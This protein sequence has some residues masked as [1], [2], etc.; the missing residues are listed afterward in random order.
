LSKK[1]LIGNFYVPGWGGPATEGYKMFE[2]MQ[3][4]GL[5]VSY[6]NI[7]SRPILDFFKNKFGSNFG[8]PKGL[9]N[10]YNY[11]VEW[12]ITLDGEHPGLS[13]F[14]NKLSPDITVGKMWRA[15]FLL[16][17]AAPQ[18]PMIFLPSGCDQLKTYI[19]RGEVKDFISL[20]ARFKHPR[21]S[22]N[23]S[24]V[25]N[26]TVLQSDLIVTHS[27]MTLSLYR[28]FFPSMNGK[29]YPE[30][31]WYADWIFKEAS[32]Y[33]RQ[34]LP[35]AKRDIDL[36][37]VAND[38]SRP[39][40]NYP[41]L[42]KIALRCKDLNIHLVGEVNE[43]SAGQT[44]YGLVTER[45]KLF[46]LMGRARIVVSPSLFDAAPN[47]LFEASAIGCNVICSKNCGNWQLCNENLLVDPVSSD[48]FIKKIHLALRQKYEDNKAYFVRKDSYK[49][50][51]DVILKFS[52]DN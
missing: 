8:N 31:F 37:F 2:M 5:N 38:W 10:V 52:I 12:P 25:E 23:P 1:I 28:Y 39:E 43:R 19:R 51:V 20:S 48:N 7:I 15:A 46:S 30:V 50:L 14:L 45:K 36:L 24:I 49:K 16:K 32:G 4:Q 27:E 18:T 35:F 29:I 33:F 3:A 42:K 17:R 40:K 44:Y 34:K 11:V 41:L 6:L 13:S 21:S 26:E 47:I 9:T 22:P